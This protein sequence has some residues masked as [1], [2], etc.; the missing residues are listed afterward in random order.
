MSQ[1]RYA[2]DEM[3]REDAERAEKIATAVAESRAARYDEPMQFTSLAGDNWHITVEKSLITGVWLGF[4]SNS[5]SAG[6]TLTTEQAR[7]LADRLNQAA[8]SVEQRL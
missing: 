1:G 3:V 2:F 8:T 5:W 4:V 6:L 7:E